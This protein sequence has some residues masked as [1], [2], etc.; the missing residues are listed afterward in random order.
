MKILVTGGKGQLGNE[1]QKIAISS[2]H[3]FTFCDIDEMDLSSENSILNFLDTKRLDIIINCGA[4]TNVDGAEENE[5]LARQIN[6]LAPGIIAKYCLKTNT[7]LIHIST[8]Y[9]FDGKGNLPIDENT[10][11]NPLSVY[12]KTKLEGELSVLNYLGNAYIFRTA[13]VYSEFGK[14]FVKTMLSLGKRNSELKVVYDQV[15]SP[16]YAADLANNIMNIVHQWPAND[17]PG[18]YNFSNHGVI[19]WYDFANTIFEISGLECNVLPVRSSE[20]VTKALRPAYSVLDTD[21]ICSTFKLS[22]PYWKDSLKKCI[23][24]LQQ[25][26]R[27]KELK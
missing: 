2:A 7:R 14:N 27:S 8:D 16:T 17:K 15:G 11:P 10:S 23:D 21:K 1:F 22:I 19:S 13:W 20:F 9:V 12:G 18:I 26:N 6:G 24:D 3:D 5:R 25:R 4:Y